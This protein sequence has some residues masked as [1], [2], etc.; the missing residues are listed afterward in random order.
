MVTP[1]TAAL[2]AGKQGSNRIAVSNRIKAI[3]VPKLGL[4]FDN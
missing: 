2:M 1:V 4:L 3:V